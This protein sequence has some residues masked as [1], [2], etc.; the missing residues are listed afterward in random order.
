D[1]AKALL[2]E[3]K[4]SPIVKARLLSSRAPFA[5]AWLNSPLGDP[6]L[7][8]NDKFFAMAVRLRLGLPPQDW[9]SSSLSFLPQPQDHYLLARKAKLGDI[10]TQVEVPLED[11]KRLMSP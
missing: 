1:G 4:A 8:L 11:L 7:R 6:L 2:E 5:G 10:A 9:G 3:A